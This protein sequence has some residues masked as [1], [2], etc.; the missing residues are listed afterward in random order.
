MVVIQTLFTNLTLLCHIC[1]TVC[2]PTVTHDWFPVVLCKSWR[3]P[4]VGQEMLIISGTPDFTPFWE[5]M[6]SPIHYIYGLIL[7][8]YTVSRGDRWQTPNWTEITPMFVWCL[9]ETSIMDCWLHVLTGDQ[10]HTLSMMGLIIRGTRGIEQHIMQWGEMGSWKGNTSFNYQ[11]LYST[12][13][14]HVDTVGSTQTGWITLSEA[15]LA[16]GLWSMHNIAK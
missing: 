5:F 15:A 11:P 10:L 1:W 3:V 7:F 12:H 13:R 9:S 2:S 16:P 14:F 6:I 4:H 8:Q